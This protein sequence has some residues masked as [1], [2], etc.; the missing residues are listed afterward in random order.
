MGDLK[1]KLELKVDY[2]I[3]QEFFSKLSFPICFIGKESVY[4]EEFGYDIIQLSIDTVDRDGKITHLETTDGDKMDELGFEQLV[5]KAK[6]IIY[7]SEYIIKDIS[8]II[9]EGSF[10]NQSIYDLLKPKLM[11]FEELFKH[12]EDWKCNHAKLQYNSSEVLNIYTMLL[13]SLR[14]YQSK[15]NTKYIV[16]SQNSDYLCGKYLKY[17]KYW[18]KDPLMYI[19]GFN[20]LYDAKRFI[21]KDNHNYFAIISRDKVVMEYSKLKYVL[22]S[23]YDPDFIDNMNLRGYKEWVYHY[24]TLYHEFRTLTEARRFRIKTRDDK[25]FNY[26]CI[27]R[28]SDGKI[29]LR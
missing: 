2:S 17:R 20:S 7:F 18:R 3:V 23:S 26:T 8:S 27:M 22:F 28:I 25:I 1:D 10:F 21:G 13:E 6:T 24:G 12:R 5:T 11:N 29:W 16:I 14:S 9:Y 4:V 19:V 15:L